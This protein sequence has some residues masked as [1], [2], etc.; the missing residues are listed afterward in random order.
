MALV[1]RGLL[2]AVLNAYTALDPTLN[3][4]RIACNVP[5]IGAQDG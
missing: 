4:L 3:N 2:Q 5:K 1:V